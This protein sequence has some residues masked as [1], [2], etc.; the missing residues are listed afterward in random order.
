MH[1]CVRL[2]AASGASTAVFENVEG[3]SDV[4]RG[5]DK[6]PL[7][8]FEQLLARQGFCV[9][10]IRICNS[11][12]FPCLRPRTDHDK[13]KKHNR[14]VCALKHSYFVFLSF[15]FLVLRIYIIACRNSEKLAQMVGTM[16]GALEHVLCYR[17]NAVR[18]FLLHEPEVCE[19]GW[20]LR[21]CQ[22]RQ[23]CQMFQN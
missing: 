19:A 10:I 22:S 13:Q 11:L 16:E 4:T 15:H 5:H 14:V 23:I 21:C 18:D 8:V 3:F 7:Q 9:H 1:A 17:V 2:L 12:F 20:P 6:S